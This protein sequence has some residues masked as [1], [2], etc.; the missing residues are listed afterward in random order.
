[1][2]S[3]RSPV[4]LPLK[5]GFRDQRR[6]KCSL[7]CS[8][9]L[10]SS[11]NL[12][13][14]ATLHA[15]QRVCLTF[16]YSSSVQFSGG[17]GSAFF[18]FLF[19]C[20]S[21]P[22]LPL[23]FNAMS[24]RPSTESS[25][26][27]SGL[28]PPTASS[29]ERSP[30]PAPSTASKARGEDYVYFERSTEGFSPDA[31]S[32][33]TAAKLKLES[34]YKLAVDVAIERNGRYVIVRTHVASVISLALFVSHSRV[35]LEQ[36]I[37][38]GVIPNEAKEREIRKYRKLESQ[39]LRLRRT[40]IRL[41]DFRTV[42]VIGKGAFGEVRLSCIFPLYN[43]TFLGA[44]SACPENGYWQG[45]CDEDVAKGGNVETG[46]GLSDAFLAPGSMILLC[47]PS[48]PMSVQ[49]VICWRNRRHHGWFSYSILSKIRYTSISSWNSF[50]EVIS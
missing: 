40:K 7:V 21:R 5:P 16:I 35:E 23:S 18:F 49:S 38:Q 26:S 46:P 4:D 37:N 8:H 19:S 30:S 1:M 45:I 2:T 33:A 48:L 24:Q 6:D 14:A 17:R 11:P 36:K 41:S 22:R 50:P 31:V 27:A 15:Y 25:G 34:Y 10:E 42:K 47:E 44:G 28:N 32:R 29:Q 43:V 13:L 20:V 9:R 39:H 3:W 12:T